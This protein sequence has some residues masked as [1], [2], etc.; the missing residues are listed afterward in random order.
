M[1]KLFTFICLLAISLHSFA[2]VRTATVSG[3]WNSTT[4]WGGTVPA[5]NDDVVIN[6]GVTVTINVN[7]ANINNVTVSGILQFDA[8]GTARTWTINQALTV[9]SGGSFICQVPGTAT[10][11]SLSYNG[12]GI[13]NNG[14][15]NM[16]N[17]S[18]VCNVTIGGSSTQTIGGTN[19]ITFNK[20]ALNNTGGKFQIDYASGGFTPTEVNPT[21]LNVSITTNDSLVIKQGLLIGCAISN[22][23]I[24]HSVASLK[25]GGSGS[26]IT[27][28]VSVFTQ[29]TTITVNTG[30]I[31]N[32]ASNS[33]VSLTVNSSFTSPSMSQSNAA[34]AFALNGPN[35][36]GGA[37]QSTATSIMGEWS[38]TD[39]FVCVGNSKLLG[40]VEPAQPK[41]MLYGTVHW[42]S[43]ETHTIDLPFTSDDFYIKTCFFGTFD[44][45]TA[46]PQIYLEGGDPN[47]APNAF[48]I[49]YDVF[50][51]EVQESSPLGTQTFAQISSAD[52]DWIVNGH[53]EI[54]NGSSMAVHSDHTLEINGHLTIQ[55]GGEIA[56]AESETDDSGYQPTAGP[57]LLMGESGKL[58]TENLNGLGHG[59]LSEAASDVAF[60][61]R[62]ADLDWNL[63]AIAAAGTVAYDVNTQTVTPRD[64][65][66]LTL[67]GG[68]KT[69][70]AGFVVESTMEIFSG[71]DFSNGGFMIEAAGHVSNSGTHSGSGRIVLNGTA[72]QN[73]SGAAIDW[74]NI[75]LNNAA[76]CSCLSNIAVTGTVTLTNGIMHTTTSAMLQLLAAAM[77]SSGSSSSFVAGPMSKITS[78]MAAFS[79]PLGKGGNYKALT[80]LPSSNAATTWTA[81]FF[82][83]AYGNT[84][85]LTSPVTS[86]NG[87]VHYSLTKSGSADGTLTIPFSALE[88]LPDLNGLCVASWTGAS[89][90]N[91]GNSAT[92]GNASEGTVTSALISSFN[93]FTLGEITTIATGVISGS[94]FCPGAAVNVPFTSVGTMNAGNVYTAQ[95]SNKSGS[96]SAPVNIG[97]LN[98]TA[99]S[100][101]I[102]AV[103]A[104]T[105]K[106]GTKYRIRVVSS[107]PSSIGA[108]N[109][110]NLTVTACATP[111]GITATG[112]TQTTAT[113]NWNSVACAYNYTLQYRKQGTSAWTKKKNLT[114]NSKQITGLIANTTYEYQMQTT[115]TADGKSKSGLS[116]I[117]T[118]TT[119]LRL[120]DDEPITAPM[121]VTVFPNPAGEVLSLSIGAAVDQEATLTVMNAIGEIMMTRK[122]F[123]SEGLNQWN[124][125]VASF[126]AGIYFIG[127][128]DVTS[129]VL[130]KFVKE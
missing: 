115:C 91:A 23:T 107:S 77:I 63:S 45:G 33:N 125:N 29:V 61:N 89:W 50:N 48:N 76:G 38:M 58:T 103:I 26:K 22:A 16:K 57:L 1:N 123:L 40:G 116:S 15:L 46:S 119:P 124:T 9:N 20:L 65:H 92:S 49:T 102:S 101:N 11:H 75:E 55:S 88:S 60:K 36:A 85:S 84:S 53:Y 39:I 8:T 10:A 74:G 34:T 117:Q 99:N 52:A 41:L 7:P 66:I 126:S 106:A 69:A 30:M 86:V 90:T 62:T 43:S 28:S 31:L 18:N 70:S 25:M 128:S 97:T 47:G 13:T 17:G 111:T 71:T 19:P 37:A 100:G 98:S 114:G 21:K 112:I 24:N 68:T 44:S 4:T 27:S 110:A 109:G 79:F 78:S 56:G 14:T 108:D 93:T 129:V 42:E 73:L 95:L 12:T 87:F 51:A 32:D 96:F 54:V 59:T 81:E 5:A 83:A 72:N 3:N 35:C 2:T 118:F 105:S 122:I 104:T 6:A 127:L 82:D 113:I 80:I 120:D 64:Y 121:S 94:P 67:S 130:Q